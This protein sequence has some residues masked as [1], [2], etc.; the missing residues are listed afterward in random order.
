M[1][2]RS[3]FFY[4]NKYWATTYKHVLS[5]PISIETLTT[6]CLSQRN[7]TKN[8]DQHIYYT[9][10]SPLY[11]S[12]ESLP[13]GGHSSG[14]GGGNSNITTIIPAII[15]PVVLALVISGLLMYCMYKRR[16]FYTGRRDR[17]RG[18]M[19]SSPPSSPPPPHAH[20]HNTHMGVS[21]PPFT[22]SGEWWL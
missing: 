22:V 5:S 2:S 4:I 14:Q 21:P 11:T 9:R 7:Y 18:H 15:V 1:I 19:S 20:A 10:L 12:F 3:P 8:I 13:P 6:G 17:H 16:K